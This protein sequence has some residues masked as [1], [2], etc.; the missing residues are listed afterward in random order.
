MKKTEGYVICSY[1]L[2][3]GYEYLSASEKMTYL[4]LKSYCWDKQITW[5]GQQTIAFIKRKS[6][7]TTIKDILER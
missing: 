7:Q 4:I 3:K 1:Y 6:L 5:V 2:L